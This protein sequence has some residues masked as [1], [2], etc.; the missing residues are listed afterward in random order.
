MTTCIWNLLLSM[1]KI[2]SPVQLK[3]QKIQFR[4]LY[5][6]D[7]AHGMNPTSSKYALKNT[8]HSCLC[9]KSVQEKKNTDIKVKDEYLE[10]FG[11]H[12]E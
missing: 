9:W 1:G 8:G 10:E 11:S 7:P 12:C 3:L 4:S 6:N 2:K 5:P